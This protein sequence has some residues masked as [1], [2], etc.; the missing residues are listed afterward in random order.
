MTF[1]QLSPSSYEQKLHSLKMT[2]CPPAAAAAAL[3]VQAQLLK[4]DRHSWQRSPTDPTRILHP[5]NDTK[6]VLGDGNMLGHQSR[7]ILKAGRA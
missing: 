2:F 7:K 4:E 6:Q 3:T 1:W 5:N